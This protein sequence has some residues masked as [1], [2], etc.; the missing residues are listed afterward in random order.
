MSYVT[1]YKYGYV[2]KYSVAAH[3]GELTG[4]ILDTLML[5]WLRC[6]KTSRAGTVLEE[7]F[8]CLSTTY[9]ITSDLTKTHNLYLFKPQTYTHTGKRICFS[10]SV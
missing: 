4:L 1:K 3:S 10:C 2:T 8:G 7:P 6:V 5:F 9:I